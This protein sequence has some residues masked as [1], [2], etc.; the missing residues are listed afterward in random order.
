MASYVQY[1][2]GNVVLRN[3]TKK[4]PIIERGEGPYLFAKDGKR[5]FDAAGGALVASVGHGNKEVVQSICEQLARVAYVNGTQF[6]TEPTEALATRLAGLAKGLDLDRAFFLNSGSEATEAAVKFARQLWVE[7]GEPQRNKLIAR[8]PSYHGNT[9]YALSASGRP[10]YKKYYG[11]LLSDVLTTGTP[12]EYRTQG[13]YDE[14]VAEKYASALNE[15]IE[16]EGPSSI[17]AFIVEPIVGS[18][19]GGALPPPGYFDRIQAVCRK[20]GVLIIADEIMVG[21]GRTGRFFASEWFGLKPDIL[22][23]GK[24]INGGYSAMSAVLV[25]G[26][27]LDEMKKGTGYFMHAQTFMQAPC[28]T[29]AGMAVLGFMQQHGLVKNSETVGA[30]LHA[31]LKSKILPHPHVGWIT[32]RGLFAGIEFVEDKKSKRPFSRSS[33]IVENVVAAGLDAGIT[34]WPNVGHVDGV[35]G[36]LVMLGPPL[37]ITPSQVD[38]L[39]ALLEQTLA[40]DPFH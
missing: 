21:A 40:A 4:L 23:L 32:G 37:T 34:L 13:P 6:T 15:L 39:V 28:M 9:L 29:A 18:S 35:N 10:H 33:K 11:P 19:A 38:E 14:D 17:F 24:G 36:D 8:M 22:T 2:D 26:S 25:K 12:I 1:P 7:R 31:Q 30:Y 5:Y 27:H 16:R 20:H 3:L